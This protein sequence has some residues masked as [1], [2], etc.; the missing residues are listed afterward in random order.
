MNLNLNLNW[1]RYILALMLPIMMI[2]TTP[3]V[4]EAAV[5]MGLEQ[6]IMEVLLNNQGLR[7]GVKSVEAD[8][9]AVLAAVGV[10]RPQVRGSVMGAWLTG[11]GD[12]SNVATGNMALT[13]TH[14]IDL[15]G[16]YSLDE[17]QRILGYKISRAQFDNN[18]SSL[19]ASAE[20]AWWSAVLA[21]E[22]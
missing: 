10:Q 8:Y 14:R 1:R 7:A 12:D 6:Y 20:E 5:E 21:R 15:S 2:A 4:G 11:Q 18:L 16:R 3:A 19:V 22:N 9:Y 13:V 17:R